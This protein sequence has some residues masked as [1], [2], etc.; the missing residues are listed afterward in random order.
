[1]KAE[2]HVIV[3]G[4]VSKG[5]MKVQAELLWLQGALEKVGDCALAKRGLLSGTKLWDGYFNHV[6]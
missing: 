4:P 3:I 1:M 5:G 6:I 2:A